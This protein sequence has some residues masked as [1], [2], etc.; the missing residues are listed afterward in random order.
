MR[1]DVGVLLAR[2]CGQ[3]LGRLLDVGLPE[4][5]GASFVGRAHHPGVDVAE[6][7]DAVRRRGPR[8]PRASP[9]TRRSP[10]ASPASRKPSATSPCSPLVATTSTTR[11]PSRRLGHRAAGGDATRRR[12][13]RGSRRASPSPVQ[14][15][16]RRSR[17]PRRPRGA[18]RCA[19]ASAP[20]Q[21][22]RTSSV[23][24]PACAGGRCDLARRAA[25]PRRRRGLHDAVA[26]EE[27]LAVRRCAGAAAPRPARAPA[28][29]TRRC[30][31]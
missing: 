1:E 18:W 24:W 2:G 29:S 26:L 19:S 20:S 17:R 31:P 4:R 12:D 25:E 28:R 8:R 3:P 27:R 6:E 23:C 16:H 22:P 5:P 7:L 15:T 30:P 11:W 21:S 10:S 13:G 14:A 9:S